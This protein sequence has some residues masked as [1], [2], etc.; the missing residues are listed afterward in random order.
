MGTN[1]SQEDEDAILS[2]LEEIKKVTPFRLGFRWFNLEFYWF[3]YLR[4][5][6]FSFKCFVGS[7]M[8]ICRLVQLELS[9]VQLEFR[10]FHLSKV[11]SARFSE[12]Q[13]EF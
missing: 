5:R 1:L 4:L 11:G 10:R 2:E 13:L 8:G 6:Q 3:I 12:F 7:V 9:S